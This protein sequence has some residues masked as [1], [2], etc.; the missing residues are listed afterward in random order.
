MT[1]PWTVIAEAWWHCY[2]RSSSDSIYTC[3]IWTE[4]LRRVLWS[5]TLGGRNALSAL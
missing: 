5:E 3:L 4:T 1:R 2:H